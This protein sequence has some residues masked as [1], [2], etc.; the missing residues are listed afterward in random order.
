[1][2]WTQSD[3]RTCFRA[4]KSSKYWSF[5]VIIEPL[6]RNLEFRI[7]A[8]LFNSAMH[9]KRGPIDY[10]KNLLNARSCSWSYF[11]CSGDLIVVLKSSNSEFYNYRQKPKN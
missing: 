6:R 5:L 1:M 11:Y 9:L 3:L 4:I 2:H 8:L 10:L 7:S